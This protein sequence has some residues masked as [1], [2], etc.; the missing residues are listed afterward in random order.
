MGSDCSTVV[1]CT[2]HDGEVVGSN[3]AMSWAYFSYL[4]FSILS[5]ST[6]GAL[7]SGCGSVGRAVTSDTRDLRFESKHRQNFIYQLYNRQDEN[8]EKEVGNGP[9]LLKNLPVVH[10]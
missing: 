3:P 4:S 9:S 6:S 5:L 7:G 10:P 1:E 8:K 2:L